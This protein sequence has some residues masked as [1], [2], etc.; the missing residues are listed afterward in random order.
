MAVGFIGGGNQS[1][2][3]KPPTVSH[4]MLYSINTQVKRGHGPTYG[5]RVPQSIRSNVPLSPLDQTCPSVHSIKRAPQ[6]I[7][8]NV[9]LS[10]FDQ[11]CPSVHPIKR[12]PQ[13][14]RSNVPLSPFDQTC[15]SVHSINT[16]SKLNFAS[17]YDFCIGF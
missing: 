10:P 5:K 3:R 9:S 17:F 7:R 14:I 16:Q 2:R 4:I 13:S 11:T 6:S 12:A 15:P 1:T 8:S